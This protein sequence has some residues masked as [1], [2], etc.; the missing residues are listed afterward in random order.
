MPCN[1]PLGFGI[2]G[3]RC[4]GLATRSA[5]YLTWACP[6]QW[7]NNPPACTSSQ[8]TGSPHKLSKIGG[9]LE[10]LLHC[11]AGH[12]SNKACLDF[13][14]T[15]EIAAPVAALYG[16]A[17]NARL[18]IA[19]AHWLRMVGHSP[20]V[21]KQTV[22]YTAAPALAP[23]VEKAAK[24]KSGATPGLS[25]VE[26]VCLDCAAALLQVSGKRLVVFST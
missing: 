17:L 19:R 14:C 7:S 25:A 5:I 15:Q 22:P 24:A 10:Y 1:L 4:C 2:T 13:F 20:D 6:L 16:P 11:H 23:P 8:S 18:T 21:W 3:L 12:S 9:R 26:G